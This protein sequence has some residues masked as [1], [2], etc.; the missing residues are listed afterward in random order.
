MCRGVVL[1]TREAL[2]KAYLDRA[3]LCLT[4][5][6]ILTMEKETRATLKVTPMVMLLGKCS[7]IYLTDDYYF[8]TTVGFAKCLSDRFKLYYRAFIRVIHVFRAS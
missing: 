2:S 8:S 1:C 3:L 4:A 7:L 6:I 5:N